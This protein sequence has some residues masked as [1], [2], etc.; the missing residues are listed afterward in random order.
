MTKFL[1]IAIRPLAPALAGLAVFSAGPAGAATEITEPAG[2]SVPFSNYQPSLVLNTRIATT[3]VFPCRDCGYDAPPT[4]GFVRSFAY[5]YGYS[6]VAAPQTHGQ[7]LQIASNT[8]LF[9]ILGTYYGG[10]GETT[11]ALPDLRAAAPNNHTYSIC[12]EG[13]YPSRQ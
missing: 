3:G 6:P 4:I 5:N 8:A 10:D 9:S 13:I 2:A 1:N 7:L 12:T 11:F